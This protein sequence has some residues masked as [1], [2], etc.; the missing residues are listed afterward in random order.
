MSVLAV[1]SQ[2]VLTYL[3]YLLELGTISVKSLQ[4]YLSLINTV[5]NDFEYLSPA[6]GYL[7]KLV[8]KGFVELQGSSMLQT[9]VVTVFP[10]EHMFTTVIM[11]GRR[12][13]ASKHHIRV[14]VCLAAQFAFFSRADS[15]VL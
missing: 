4:T 15:G 11:F 5:H 10:A 8:R 3:G 6:C 2:T 7:V 13:N 9:Q 14:C 12:P 1:S